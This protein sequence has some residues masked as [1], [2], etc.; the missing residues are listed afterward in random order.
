MKRFLPFILIFSVILQFFAPFTIDAAKPS[1][2]IKRSTVSAEDVTVVDHD[3][4]LDVKGV[5]TDKTVTLTITPKRADG[6]NSQYTVFNLNIFK[7]EAILYVGDEKEDTKS[8]EVEGFTPIEIKFKKLDPDTAYKVKIKFFGGQVVSQMVGD[9]WTKSRT[10]NTIPLGVTDFDFK[11]N[12]KGDNQ[13]TTIADNI[14][15]ES[16]QSHTEKK[17]DLPECGVFHIG[18]CIARVFYYLFYMPTSFLFGLA[19]KAMDYTLMYSLS[20]GSYRTPFVSEG[21]K[22]VRDL[23]NMF[24]IFILLY[25]AFTTILDTAGAKN[26]STVINVVIIGLVINFS[27]FATHV[28]IDASNILARVFYNPKIVE[29]EKVENGQ[30]VKVGLDEDYKYIKISETIVSKV[31]PQNLLSQKTQ[32]ITTSSNQSKGAVKKGEEDGVSTGSFILVTLLASIVNVMGMM[33]FLSIALS[34]IGRVIGLWLAMVLS[35]IAFL[36]FTIPQLKNV[37][38]IGWT[39]WWPETLK[40]AF[41]APVFVFFLYIILMFLES[42]LGIAQSAGSSEVRGL[43][44]ILSIIIPFVLIIVLLKQAQKIANNMAGEIASFVTDKIGK[45]A[46][47]FVGGAALGA[48]TGGGAMLMRGTVGKL[49]AGLMNSE[50]LKLAESKG[51]I[52]GMMAKQLRNVG[53]FTSKKSFDVRNTSLGKAAGKELGADLGKGKTGGYAEYQNSLAKKKIDRSDT[54]KLSD[55]KAAEQDAAAKEYNDKYQKSMYAE[56]ANVEKNGGK[57]N[58]KEYKEKYKNDIKEQEKKKR[59]QELGERGKPFDS[60]EQEKFE[61]EYRERHKNDGKTSSQIDRERV[62]EYQ[63]S[64]KRGGV[65]GA[66]DSTMARI[67]KGLEDKSKDPDAEKPLTHKENFLAEKNKA[68]AEKRVSEIGTTITKMEEVRKAVEGEMDDIN[69][70]LAD[71]VDT[72][73]GTMDPKDVNKDNVSQAMS[74]IR[75]KIAQEEARIVSLS[76]IVAQN[77]SN[78]EAQRALANANKTKRI[79]ETNLKSMSTVL[80]RKAKNKEKDINLANNIDKQLSIKNK[81]EEEL[82]KQVEIINRYQKEQEKKP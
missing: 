66:N 5:T 27:L 21:W 63:E 75:D 74:I 76:N 58:E 10:Y 26:K 19:G 39:K 73:D 40:T 61:K 35:P 52:S 81:Q 3:F 51:G 15:I 80:E 36:T 72:I 22:I 50:K 31:N 34:F 78:Q 48:L 32:D 67:D 62:K 82:E 9:A 47:S 70:E 43:N 60:K 33:S 53:D 54:F 68:L 41:M 57:F 25:I 46:A 30:P 49:G 55:A 6:G 1:I 38:Y 77:P 4:L 28:I 16:T 71:V 13:E 65:L 11:T 20:D 37:Q 23:C 17:D 18:G 14:V 56:R 45:P 2:A 42:G 79:Q 12:P 7:L 59:I 29:I 69:K 44:Y 24:F 8:E 64:I